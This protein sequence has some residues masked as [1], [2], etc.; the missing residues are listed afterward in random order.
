MEELLNEIEKLERPDNMKEKEELIKRDIKLWFQR[1]IRG[2]SD[3]ECW[4]LDCE[5]IKW[6][7]SRLI[8]YKN[9]A[10]KIVDLEYHKFIYKDEEYTQSQLVDKLIDITNWFINNDVFELTWSQPEKC[11]YMKNEML[12]I[13]KLIYWSLWW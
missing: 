12:D 11:E 8:V 3:D 5:F 13:F 2:W 4:N 9:E 7:N 1:R 10:S 6:L